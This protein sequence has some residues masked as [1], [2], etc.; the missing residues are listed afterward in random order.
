MY[1]CP[2]CKT[3]SEILI[4]KNCGFDESCDCESYPTLSVVSVSSKPIS[5]FK[6]VMTLV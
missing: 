6:R 2:V 1:I 3:K 5:V 4:C